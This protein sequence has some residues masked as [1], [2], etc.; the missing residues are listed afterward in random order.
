LNHNLQ[1]IIF[2]INSYANVRQ[3]GWIKADPDSGVTRYQ[4]SRLCRGAVAK[5]N[6]IGRLPPPARR[7]A[8]PCSNFCCFPKKSMIF[9]D[10]ESCLVRVQDQIRSDKPVYHNPNFHFQMI[11]F[12]QSSFDVLLTL[13]SRIKDFH[14]K[15]SCQI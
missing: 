7:S 1:H 9:V 2:M 3:K 4:L 12:D 11:I 10:R 6:L 15:Y 8:A 5:R 13:I 14:K